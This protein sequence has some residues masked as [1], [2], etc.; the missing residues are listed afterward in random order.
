VARLATEIGERLALSP[1]QLRVIYQ[2]GLLHDIGKIGIADEILNKPGQL[3]PAEFA[4]VKGHPARSEEM[5][6]KIPSLRPTLQAIRWHH[7]RLDGS[8]YPDGIAGNAIPLDAR[9]LAVADVYD[10]MVSGRSYRPALGEAHALAFLQAHAGRLFDPRCVDAVRH[11]VTRV[12]AAPRP[13]QTRAPL[14]L[15]LDKQPSS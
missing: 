2:A 4:V 1:E 3:T 9:I 15:Q 6:G 10:A 8:G 13:S 14:S 7:E 12:E 5:I 11:V